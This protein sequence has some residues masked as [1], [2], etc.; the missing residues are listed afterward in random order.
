MAFD[1]DA[2]VQGIVRFFVPHARLPAGAQQRTK[3]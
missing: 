1:A 2:K 3:T